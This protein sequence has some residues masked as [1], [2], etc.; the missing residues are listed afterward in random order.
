MLFGIPGGNGGPGVT[1]KWHYF[2]VE[3]KNQIK[4]LVIDRNLW[5]Y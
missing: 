1:L 4:N 5:K 2:R 3:D